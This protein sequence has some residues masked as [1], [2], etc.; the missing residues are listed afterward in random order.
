M[1]DVVIAFKI[2]SQW[3]KNYQ[4]KIIG[5]KE[6]AET[7]RNGYVYIFRKLRD[8]ERNTDETRTRRYNI[9]DLSKTNKG[10]LP[11]RTLGEENYY[12][13]M[14][15]QVRLPIEREETI[16]LELNRLIRD[17]RLPNAGDSR[18][19]YI[20][21]ERNYT[22]SILGI[23]RE[24]YLRTDYEELSGN[25][26]DEDI[27][28][29]DAVLYLHDWYGQME[30]AVKRYT[31]SIQEEDARYFE[32]EVPLTNYNTHPHPQHAGARLIDN[33]NFHA[34][35]TFSRKDLYALT[36][37][38][39]EL[40]KDGSGRDSTKYMNN[41][42][43]LEVQTIETDPAKLQT[44]ISSSDVFH[45][46]TIPCYRLFLNEVNERLA[47]IRQT[48]RPCIQDII[49]ILEIKSA[50]STF[51]DYLYFQ[52]GTQER[53]L[54]LLADSIIYNELTMYPED[55]RRFSKIFEN[56]FAD[57]ERI[58]D[59]L[60]VGSPSELYKKAGEAS[61]WTQLFALNVAAFLCTATV[62]ILDELLKYMR[63]I[64][65]NI[66]ENMVMILKKGLLKEFTARSTYF[67]MTQAQMR[68]F[69]RNNKIAYRLNTIDDAERLW[70]RRVEDYIH[71][72]NIAFFDRIE[73][74]VSEADGVKKYHIAGTL[75]E[76][77]YE[78]IENKINRLKGAK[79]LAQSLSLIMAG[80]SI[81]EQ[82]CFIQE[83]D[84]LAYTI[85]YWVNIA[86]SIS[87]IIESQLSAAGAVRVAGAVGWFLL[88]LESA[89]H[90]Y[91]R[92]INNDYDAAGAYAGST[93]SFAVAGVI[94]LFS[95]PG[96]LVYGFVAAGL[97]LNL[98]ANY[99]TDDEKDIFL[100][101]SLWGTEY[102]ENWRNSDE[103]LTS[104]WP[105]DS[106]RFSNLDDI[107]YPVTLG[108]KTAKGSAY[109]LTKEKENIIP[110]H[111]IL[112]GMM[113]QIPDYKY[114]AFY[115]ET[116]FNCYIPNQ[117]KIELNLDSFSLAE[118]IEIRLR[119]FKEKNRITGENEYEEKR[120]PDFAIELSDPGS[121]VYFYRSTRGVVSSSDYTP[122][123]SMEFINEAGNFKLLCVPSKRVIV[124]KYNEYMRGIS[125]DQDIRRIE[126]IRLPIPKGILESR[127]IGERRTKY[128]F[129]TT[130][131]FKVPNYRSLRFAEAYT[132]L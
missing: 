126:D 11:V 34:D 20:S 28:H 78:T 54:S 127:I 101:Y 60:P 95:G 55:S 94:A 129:E 77:D 121:S 53:M 49:S 130:V 81:I 102:R 119:K 112:I 124:A 5:T 116:L 125:S 106:V 69:F 122:I 98:L 114:T 79:D 51:I 23:K 90:V 71:D 115:E 85:P 72:K 75:F 24:L 27:A 13:F 38:F 118:R 36:L 57:H 6:T 82:A 123:E 105:K 43:R 1:I 56:A 12:F 3:T 64:A 99:L 131:Y 128:L 65:D 132:L 2:Y 33:S 35:D 117:V 48:L 74:K 44:A 108:P 66:K 80:Y 45:N 32:T 84:S 89:V 58:I 96:A 88:G 67:E 8:S 25:Q 21:L 93:A 18:L 50:D 4:G 73:L 39:D 68:T 83:C 52:D 37:L 17:N 109:V 26:A 14:Y 62:G 30:K 40:V 29:C 19:V 61:V 59:I 76:S 41:L 31:D 91:L 110:V 16:R 15:S 103:K 107:K 87:N 86:G 46:E 63:T 70:R 113:R 22:E 120:N 111:N 92:G 100:K 42:R 47:A 104:W 97:G 9:V 10:T 7:I